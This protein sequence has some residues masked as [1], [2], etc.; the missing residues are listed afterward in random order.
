MSSF[1]LT[2]GPTDFSKNVLNAYT[3]FLSLINNIYNHI[4]NSHPPTHTPHQHYKASSHLCTREMVTLGWV[5]YRYGQV[6]D[7]EEM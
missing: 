1:W 3:S 5:L 6:K 2:H 4:I 7:N